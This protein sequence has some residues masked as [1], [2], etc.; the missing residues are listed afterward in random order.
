MGRLTEYFA[1][2][3][4][5]AR[6]RKRAFIGASM[7]HPKGPLEAGYDPNQWP[8]RVQVGGRVAQILRDMRKAHAAGNFAGF[9]ELVPRL[10]LLYDG[11]HEGEDWTTELIQALWPNWTDHGRYE[12][13]TSR[14]Y[15]GAVGDPT[16]PTHCG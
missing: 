6:T 11:L 1:R 7:P 5:T 13:D 3:N 14:E 2:L 12:A 10:Q 15:E 8:I 4:G 9:R 16:S